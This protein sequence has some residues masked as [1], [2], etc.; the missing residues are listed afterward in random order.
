MTTDHTQEHL[1]EASRI[2]L[3]DGFIVMLLLGDMTT[4]GGLLT[5]GS[6]LNNNDRWYRLSVL[7]GLTVM[8]T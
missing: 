5:W 7:L 8:L 3:S 1:L 2:S 4:L 6:N